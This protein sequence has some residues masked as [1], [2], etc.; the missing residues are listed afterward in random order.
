[1]PLGLSGGDHVN[2]IAREDRTVTNGAGCSDGAEIQANTRVNVTLCRNVYNEVLMR[3][4][5]AVTRVI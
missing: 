2:S 4:N 5:S 1:M 3:S